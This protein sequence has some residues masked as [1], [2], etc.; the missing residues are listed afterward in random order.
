[1]PRHEPKPRLPVLIIGFGVG[2][3]NAGTWRTKTAI[4]EY[5]SEWSEVS[6]IVWACETENNSHFQG[7]VPENVTVV[8]VSRNIAQNY[9]A[10]RRHGP[11]ATILAAYPAM[12]NCAL[13]LLLR[14]RCSTG[15][16][17]G[18]DFRAKT[19]SRGKGHLRRWYLIL[20]E[21]LATRMIR[22]A[23]VVFARGKALT[24]SYARINPNTIT[25]APILQTNSSLDTSN[26]PSSRGYTLFIGN[27]S[28][29]KGVDK[30]IAAV[31]LSNAQ[32]QNM[33]RVV[34]VGGGPLMTQAASVPGIE[35]V[36]YVD[37][38]A[39][40]AA[41]LQGA[42][43]LVAPSRAWGEGVPRVIEEANAF[44]R[45]VWATPNE[46]V[47]KEFADTINYFTS[48]DV[49][50]AELASVLAGEFAQSEK[51]APPPVASSPKAAAHQH[52]QALLAP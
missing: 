32:G 42:A 31:K 5:L 15:V 38:P 20:R 28:H 18:N 6:A 1:M 16:Y 41:L 21:R 49:P 37:D 33:P 9:M 22:N 11:Y 23:R 2:Q 25:T 10:L 19:V 47:Q 45:P 51:V 48:T 7:L 44:G 40:L 35:T 4:A 52:I 46:T 30:L 43:R 14:K 12:V 50:V 29:E 17:I 13:Y 8:P 36:G 27:L 24:E 3:N 39:K 34:L 26:E